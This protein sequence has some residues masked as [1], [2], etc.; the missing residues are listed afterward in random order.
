M[1]VQIN[2]DEMV[3]FDMSMY[4]QLNVIISKE[5]LSDRIGVGLAKDSKK[6]LKVVTLAQDGLAAA[7]LVRG[8]RLLSVN[9]EPCHL[10]SQTNKLLRESTE[11]TFVVLRRNESWTPGDD[12]TGR[13][14]MT[15][16]SGSETG[17]PS[18]QRKNKIGH[19]M[20]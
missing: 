17:T 18:K 7:Q 5:K 6:G 20:V 14:Q 13:S 1:G 11:I 19:T 9:G 3:D 2:L 10:E 15:S 12:E 16:S 4:E 8:D